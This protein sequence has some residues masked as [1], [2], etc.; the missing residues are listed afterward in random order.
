[1]LTTITAG[2]TGSCWRRDG[3]KTKAKVAR[4]ARIDNE[5]GGRGRDSADGGGG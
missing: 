4:G 3:G 1:M 2:E 5:H